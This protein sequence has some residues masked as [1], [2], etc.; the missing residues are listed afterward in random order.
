MHSAGGPGTTL[1]LHG[2]TLGQT[3]HTALRLMLPSWAPCDSPQAG[4]NS[5]G[6]HSFSQEHSFSFVLNTDNTATF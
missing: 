4:A 6:G 1:Q 5:S 3:L 2:W